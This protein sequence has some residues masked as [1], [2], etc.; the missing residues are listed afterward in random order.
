MIQSH[1]QQQLGLQLLKI[2]SQVSISLSSS[3]PGVSWIDYRQSC[4]P[5]ELK[6]RTEVLLE[7]ESFPQGGE[8]FTIFPGWALSSLRV[9]ELHTSWITLAGK[10]TC[11]RSCGHRTGTPQL[12]LLQNWPSQVTAHTSCVSSVHYL[13]TPSS[14][15]FSHT[16]KQGQDRSF[17]FCASEQIL[18]FQNKSNFQRT[19]LTLKD[20]SYCSPPHISRPASYPPSSQNHFLSTANSPPAITGDLKE[21][22]DSILQNIQ[23]H[24]SLAKHLKSKARFDKYSFH[25]P[26]FPV[27]LQSCQSIKELFWCY[28]LISHLQTRRTRPGSL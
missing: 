20:I 19:W 26:V 15:T 8:Y 10:S 14:F 17:T 2:S 6:L 21:K 1:C 13:T 24:R 7:L 3:Q 22:P 4:S 18:T 27:P 16:Q 11:I 28:L 5:W 25:H 9:R 23:R 12:T